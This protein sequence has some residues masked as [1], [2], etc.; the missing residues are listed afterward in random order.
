VDAAL[1]AGAGAAAA[2]V[3][4]GPAGNAAFWRQT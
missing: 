1:F 3:S 2:M 4:V